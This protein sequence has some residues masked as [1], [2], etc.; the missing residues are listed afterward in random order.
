MHGS[1]PAV[2]TELLFNPERLVEGLAHEGVR[3]P[4]I[5]D[6]EQQF[7]RTG[8]GVEVPDEGVRGALDSGGGHAG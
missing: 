4:D 2:A 8:H 3:K 1:C 6:V 7:A 5:V